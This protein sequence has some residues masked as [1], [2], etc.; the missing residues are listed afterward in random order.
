MK[1]TIKRTRNS[2]SLRV[3]S[4][5]ILGVAALAAGCG[6]NDDPAPSDAVAQPTPGPAPGAAAGPAPGPGAGPAMPPTTPPPAGVVAPPAGSF[7]AVVLAQVRA[8]SDTE[9]PL[10]LQAL[11]TPTD[12]TSEP[13]VW[14][15]GS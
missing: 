14:K 10:V 11:P 12:E 5:L 13:I 8:P 9:E 6:G 2:A 1:L 7:E 15:R 4:C 3:V